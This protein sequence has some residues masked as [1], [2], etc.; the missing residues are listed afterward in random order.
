MNVFNDWTEISHCTIHCGDKEQNWT[1][2]ID[3]WSFCCWSNTEAWALDRS[4]SLQLDTKCLMLGFLFY[5]VG[6][7]S[8]L[9]TAWP[10]F[11]ITSLS[12]FLSHVLVCQMDWQPF[13][14][15]PVNRLIMLLS[16][17]VP[18]PHIFARTPSSFCSLPSSH[19][20]TKASFFLSF[21]HKNISLHPAKTNP[22]W[23]DALHSWIDKLGVPSYRYALFQE[24]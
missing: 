23:P 10:Q 17:I 21:S 11:N 13:H 20:L 12:L 15:V 22:T 16:C 24:N 2:H 5:V 6:Y 7:C 18:S 4:S 19:N 14:P 9:M 8:S 1:S 3:H